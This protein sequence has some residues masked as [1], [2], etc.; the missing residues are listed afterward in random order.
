MHTDGVYPQ[1]DGMLELDRELLENQEPYIEIP[2]GETRS[3]GEV[4]PREELDG[5]NEMLHTGAPG[6]QE[7]AGDG[8]MP[9][10]APHP[11]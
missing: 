7:P 8:P 4:S 6:V 10:G 3:L 11:D 5:A 2:D 9:G 1:D